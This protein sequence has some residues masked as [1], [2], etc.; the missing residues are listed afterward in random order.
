MAKARVKAGGPTRGRLRP[1]RL[2]MGSGKQLAADKK[3]KRG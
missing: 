3:A 1:K 2:G